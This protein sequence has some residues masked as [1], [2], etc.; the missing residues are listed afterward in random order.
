[1]RNKHFKSAVSLLLTVMLILSAVLCVTAAESD[2]AQTGATGT[3]YYENSGNWSSVYCYMWNGNGETKNADWP[4]Q[5]MTNFKGNV[6]K[7]TTTTSYENV[8]FNNGDNGQQTSDLKFPGDGQIFNGSWSAYSEHIVTNPTDAPTTA[9]TQKPTTTPTPTPGS[10]M[11]YF[12]NTAGWGDVYCYMW[13]DDNNKNSLWPGQKM[14]NIGENIWQY[15]VTGNW[16]NIIFNNNSGTQTGDMSFPGGGYIYDY[17]AN[18]WEK[19][20]TSPITVKST[21]TDVASP[22]YKGCDI[23]LT[24]NATS[25]GGTVYYKFSV[26]N[27]SGSTT[28]LSDFSTKNTA[29]WSPTATGTYTLVYDFKDAAGN[30]NQRTATYE[31]KDDSTVKEPVIKKVTPGASQIKKGTATTISVSAGGGKTGTNLLFYKF[32]VKDASGKIVNVP[33]YTKTASYKFTPTA[34]GAYTVTVSVQN[35]DND[36]AERSYTYQSVNEVTEEPSETP[37]ELPTDAPTDGPTVKPGDYLKGDAN[38]DGEVTVID[39]TLVQQFVAQIVTLGDL[40]F[41]N[42]DVDGDKDLSVM[43]AT[44]IQRFVAKLESW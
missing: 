16:N 36:L 43:D 8:I 42:S 9:P 29:L 5:P 38:E 44:L 34:L 19:Y 37:S 4:G 14:T 2:V 17:S 1:M 27:A 39:A 7:Y 30:E 25:T 15:E 28:V 35:S 22:Q 21:A 20:D 24:A 18:K 31:V 13:V 26:K 11:V 40:N 3:V 41:D 10:K 6:F 33:Y 32:T 23:T 12:K